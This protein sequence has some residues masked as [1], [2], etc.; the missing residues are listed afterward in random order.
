MKQRAGLDAPYDPTPGVDV[1]R[2][3]GGRE[4]RVP[5]DARLDPAEGDVEAQILQ[6]SHL[7]FQNFAILTLKKPKFCN[8]RT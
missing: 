5:R 1:Y 3:T 6:I 8:F 2:G 7:K 4:A